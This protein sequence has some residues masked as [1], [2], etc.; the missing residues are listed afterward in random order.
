MEL[1]LLYVVRPPLLS[2]TK[3]LVLMAASLGPQA[4]G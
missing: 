4:G 1:L 3:V 2:E